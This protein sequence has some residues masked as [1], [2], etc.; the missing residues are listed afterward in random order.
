MTKLKQNWQLVLI[1]V[2]TLIL[3][4]IAIL[5]AMRLYRLGKEPVAPTVPEETPAVEE[6][7]PNAACTTE[8]IVPEPTPVPQECTS[9]ASLSV[10]E[11]TGGTQISATAAIPYTYVAIKT[12]TSAGKRYFTNPSVNSLGGDWQ[13]VFET[14]VDFASLQTVAF[15]ID[16]FGQGSEGTLCGTWTPSLT[17]TPT[18]TGTP[19]PSPTPTLTGTPA[20]Q[21]TATPTSRPTG[22]STPTPTRA[23]VTPKATPTP[24]ELP[25]AGVALPTFTIII[26]ALVL[27]TFAIVLA[28]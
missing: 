6:R 18:L 19:T 25:T 10:N 16:Y 21:P 20:P 8:F 11:T 12:T 14:D 17:P 4:I 15:V 7:Q 3:G 24:V 13:W 2:A 9:L 1:G 28:L 5:T 23:A 27:F 22:T 26:G